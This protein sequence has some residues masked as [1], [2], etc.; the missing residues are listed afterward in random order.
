M[1][2]SSV[3]ACGVNHER[4]G[5][6]WM[7]VNLRASLWSVDA[8]LTTSGEACGVVVNHERAAK[9]RALTTS[10]GASL[11]TERRG[12]ASLLTTSVEA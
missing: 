4:R 9:R 11:T 6:A 8:A 2:T 3:E 12:E 10:V 5:E 1:L 7:R